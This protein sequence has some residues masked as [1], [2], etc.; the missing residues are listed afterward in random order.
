M[1]K[2]FALNCIIDVFNKLTTDVLYISKTGGF[3]PV[4]SASDPL[5]GPLSKQIRRS[6]GKA[7]KGHANKN[8]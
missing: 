4:I 3:L 7:N 1:T 8:L 2:L 5:V 6:K